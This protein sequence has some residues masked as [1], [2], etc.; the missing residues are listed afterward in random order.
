MATVHLVTPNGAAIKAIREARGWS[1]R[2]L[3]R[4]IERAASTVSR[5]E[6]GAGCTSDTRDRIAAALDVH[7]DAIT[8]EMT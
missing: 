4:L 5:I 7:P 6:G 3:A 8:K 2:H 1:M